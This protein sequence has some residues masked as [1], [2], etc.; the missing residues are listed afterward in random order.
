MKEGVAKRDG[1]KGLPF[2]TRVTIAG[3]LVFALIVTGLGLLGMVPGGV[4]G[5]D[6]EAVGFYV[7][8]FMIPTTVV[9]VLAWRKPELT[10]VVAG[11]AALVLLTLAPGTPN[12]LGSFNS[13][14]DAGLLVPATVSLVVAVVAG[15]VSFLQHRGARS[16]TCPPQASGG[17]SGRRRPWWSGSWSSRARS[18]SPALNR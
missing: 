17:F 3:L 11:W 5:S 13:F 6:A 18:T 10:P 2:H 8:A 16:A 1:W 15:I 14:F 4:E 9:V 12:A 7:L